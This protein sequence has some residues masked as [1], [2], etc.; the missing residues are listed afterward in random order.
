MGYGKY[1]F[2]DWRYLDLKGEQQKPEFVL[3]L[4]QFKD[5]EILIAGKNFGCGSSREHAPWA[6][7][8]FGIKVGYGRKL[9]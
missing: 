7:A 2:H 6:I 4:P 3:N 9:C 8:D 5:A 1:L